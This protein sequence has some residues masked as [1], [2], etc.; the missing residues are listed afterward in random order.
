MYIFLVIETLDISRTERCFKLSAVEVTFGGS[1]GYGLIKPHL[2]LFSDFWFLWGEYSV[3]LKGN[4]NETSNCRYCPYL[5]S[6][7]ISLSTIRA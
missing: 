5:K 2:N 4:V 6:I 7:I 1:M 3:Y